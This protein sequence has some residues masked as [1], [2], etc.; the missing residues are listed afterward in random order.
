M[1]KLLSDQDLWGTGGNVVTVM[2]PSPGDLFVVTTMFGKASMVKP[3][4]DYDAAVR[5][6]QAFTRRVRPVRPVVIKIFCVT[7]AEAVALGFIP[8]DV[9]SDWTPEEHAEMRAAFI[10]ACKDALRTCNDPAVRAD[11]LKLL[12]DW[13]VLQ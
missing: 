11:A 10:T 6:A 9:F 4:T 12:T 5:R 13:G 8:A 3:I 7:F 2:P 1:N